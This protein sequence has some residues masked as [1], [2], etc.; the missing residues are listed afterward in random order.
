ML[1]KILSAILGL[2]YAIIGWFIAEGERGGIK[3]EAI[4]KIH[5]AFGGILAGLVFYYF[6]SES[7]WAGVAAAFLLGVLFLC[8]QGCAT[9]L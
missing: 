8:L 7:G 5:A 9:A 4:T 6:V 3:G 2:L 1:L